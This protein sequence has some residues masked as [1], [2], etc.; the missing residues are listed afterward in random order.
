MKLWDD[1]VLDPD[2]AME[3]LESISAELQDASPEE[4]NLI[5]KVSRQLAKSAKSEEVKGF[6]ENFIDDFGLE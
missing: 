5:T 6:F 2:I 1:D 3:A 4:K